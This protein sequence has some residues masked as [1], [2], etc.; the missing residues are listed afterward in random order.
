[1]QCQGDASY[2]KRTVKSTAIE[3]IGGSEMFVLSA[4][5]CLGCLLSLMIFR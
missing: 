2:S 5:D 4:P 1:M 3:L